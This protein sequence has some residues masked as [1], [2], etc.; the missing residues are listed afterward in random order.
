MSEAPRTSIR[1]PSAEARAA[2]EGLASRLAA[3]EI[4]V[5]VDQQNGYADVLLGARLPEFKL[6]DRR[7]VFG[8]HRSARSAGPSS[9]T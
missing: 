3:V 9:N 8:S 7:P 1:R 4:L 6:A 2:N 5:R